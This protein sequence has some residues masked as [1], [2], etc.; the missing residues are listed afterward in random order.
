MPRRSPAPELDLV[1]IMN[2]V[3]IL[4]PFLLFSASF[5]TLAT[6]DSTLPALAPPPPITP[7]P[8]PSLH[9]S[10]EVTPEGYRLSASQPLP[11]IPTELPVTERTTRPGAW[12]AADL[13][14]ALT[15]IKDEYPSEDT[16]IL[17]PS[18]SIPY[19]VLV[20]TMDAARGHDR[21]LFPAVVMAGGGA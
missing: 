13:T 10:V 9:L 7:D 18:P 8:A 2:L 6:I 21:A 17:V 14:E 1:P 20:N 16:L 12:P 5:V 19:E 15:D 3:T 11:D 4:I